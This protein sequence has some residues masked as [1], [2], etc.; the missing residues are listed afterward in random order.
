L[1]FYIP[2]IFS[3]ISNI[4]ESIVYNFNMY[5]KKDYFWKELQLKLMP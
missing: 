5:E 3:I 2:L 4:Y 1:S